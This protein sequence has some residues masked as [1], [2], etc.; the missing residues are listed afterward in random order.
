MAVKKE[1]ADWGQSAASFFHTPASNSLEVCV[2]KV[3][4]IETH[5]PL[6]CLSAMFLLKRSTGTM[7]VSP[8]MDDKNQLEEPFML[9]LKNSTHCA[10]FVMAGLLAIVAGN[11]ATLVNAQTTRATISGTVTDEK[12]AVVANAKIIAKNLDTNLSRE[13]KSDGAGRYRIP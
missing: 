10:S 13:T 9:T 7:S 6:S 4:K 3:V 8:V 12:G 11:F 1:A 2:R 5:S